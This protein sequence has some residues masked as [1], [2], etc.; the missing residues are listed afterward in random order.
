MFRLM[1]WQTKEGVELKA[2]EN[3]IYREGKDF[4][5]L[6][7]SDKWSEAMEKME[8]LY[9]DHG[10]EAIQGLSLVR[11]TEASMEMLMGLGRWDQAEEV[12]LSFLALR[13]GRSAE[14]ARMIL[15]VASL[16][17]R[18]IPEAI[19]RLELLPDEDV[20]SAKI[21]MDCINTRPEN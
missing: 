1:L 4:R 14:I 12:A 16:A 11:R 2:I 15:A 10:E 18:D 9:E 6:I 8:L 17:Q 21:E 20:E 5:T 3:M 13:A 19:P 7:S